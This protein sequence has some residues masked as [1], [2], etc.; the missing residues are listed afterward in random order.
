MTLQGMV[1]DVFIVDM[2][3]EYAQRYLEVSGLNQP[4]RGERQTRRE[5]EQSREDKQ[6]KEEQKAKTACGLDD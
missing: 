3:E 5:G 6:R 4:T 2:R 1:E